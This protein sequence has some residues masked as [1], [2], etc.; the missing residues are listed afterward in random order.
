MGGLS[1]FLFL[2]LTFTGLLLM[3]LL[4]ADARVR[5]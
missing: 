4:P 3:F 5:L 1:F 2:V